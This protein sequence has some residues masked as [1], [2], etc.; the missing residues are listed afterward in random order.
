MKKLKPEGIAYSISGSVLFAL[1]IGAMLE[2]VFDPP[3]SD[4]YAAMVI[5]AVAFFIYM[6]YMNVT[7]DD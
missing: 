7:E 5:A 2:S 3:S 4:L 6:I 1:T